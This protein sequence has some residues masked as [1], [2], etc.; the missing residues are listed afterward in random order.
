MQLD[1]N[2]EIICTLQQNRKICCV[3]FVSK[4]MIK[5]YGFGVAVLRL[6]KRKRN[7]LDWN[8]KKA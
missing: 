2:A 1:V 8:E 5:K 7:K 6:L 3:I 4:Y